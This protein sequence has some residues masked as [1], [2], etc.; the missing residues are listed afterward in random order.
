MPSKLR[1]HYLSGAFAGWIATTLIMRSGPL[2]GIF[3][4]A[5]NIFLIF[6]WHMLPKSPP[7]WP[8]N[9][10]WE[11]QTPVHTPKTS[12]SPINPQLPQCWLFSD[13]TLA[14]ICDFACGHRQ[15]N[16]P[17]WLPF[18]KPYF[19][20]TC[21]HDGYGKQHVTSAQF[22]LFAQNW[23]GGC[24]A[25][26]EA[27]PPFTTWRSCQC[28]KIVGQF[29]FADEPLLV[30]AKSCEINPILLLLNPPKY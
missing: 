21:I 12:C 14:L 4:N 5:P 17:H 26:V 10:I 25:E 3:C 28:W 8:D 20:F 19:V 13:G 15:Q 9:R 6:F 24:R 22:S 18:S 2:P 23:F 27:R 16:V 30:M 1:I 29:S 11:S 7:Q